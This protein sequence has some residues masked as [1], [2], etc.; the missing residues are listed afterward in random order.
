MTAATIARRVDGIAERVGRLSIW[1]RVALVTLAGGLFRLVFL[2]QQELWRDEAFTAVVVKR[3]LGDMLA[4]IAHDSA[5]PLSYLLDSAIARVDDSPWALRLVPAIAGTALIPLVAALA[6]RIRGDGAAI[7]AAAFAAL[8]PAVVL[9]ARD[10]RMYALGGTLAVAAVW[11]LWRA[12]DHPSRMRWLAYA[13]V[14]AAAIWTE[15]FDAVAIAAALAA[16]GWWLRPDRRTLIAALAATIMPALS[17]VPWL[18]IARAQF[19]HAATPFWVEPLGVVPVFGSLVQFVTGPQI[20]PGVPLR[21]PLQ[22]LQT[23]A[24]LGAL[25]AFG[26]LVARWTSLGREGRRAAWFCLVAGAGG[27]VV[28]LIVSVVRP[29]F[30]ARY[31]SVTWLPLLVLAGA[32]L[33]LAPRRVGV[34]VLVLLF[35]P[36]LVL[37]VAPSRA[38]T[39]ELLPDLAGR[40]GE[41]DFVEASPRQYLLL[42]AEAEPSLAERVHV[43]GDVPWYWGTAAYPPGAVVQAVPASVAS[44][45]GRVLA[46]GEPEDDPPTV[47]AGYVQTAQVCRIRVC[48]TV[49]APAGASGAAAGQAVPDGPERVARV[50][51]P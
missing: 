47:P 13:I 1:Q 18:F 34:A 31:A 22:A 5:P 7:W 4:A 28:L 46:I 32:G 6:R 21:L 26:W 15:Y 10:A 25:L 36:S 38:Q 16:A 14:V 37:S 20:D 33:S 27:G 43:V 39:A 49:Y 50:T 12:I 48:L 3:P 30:E 2:G 41:R 40:V 17:L 29:L 51:L 23:A 35:L 11:L 19:E 9:S 44:E 45:G 8:L 42:L 24:G